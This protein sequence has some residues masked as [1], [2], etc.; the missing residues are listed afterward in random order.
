MLHTRAKTQTGLSLIE[1]MI[2][3]VVGLILIAGVLS[4]YI[5]SRQGY[6]TNSAVGEVQENGRFAMGF[7]GNAVRQA[8]YMGCSVSSQV[9]NDLNPVSGNLPYDFGLGVVGFEYAGTAPGD[10]LPLSGTPTV[11]ASTDWSPT[12]DASLPVPASGGPISQND[13][14]PG[15]DVLVVRY[16]DNDPAYVTSVTS[17]NSFN[18]QGGTT[19]TPGNIVLATNCLSG[20]VM[21][22]TGASAS[23]TGNSVTAAVGGAYPPGNSASANLPQSF[24][25]A[26]VVTP[27]TTALY[28]GQ[29]L[30]KRPALFEAVTDPNAASGFDYNE[31]VPGVEN[32]QVL[33]GLDTNGTRTP[34][35][36]VTADNVSNWNQVVSV[37]VALLV[38]SNPGAIPVPTAAPIYKLL[39][40]NVTAPDDTRLRRVFVSDIYI[41]N[42]QPAGS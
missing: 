8:G 16:V 2:A 10:T 29:G 18:V 21:Q 30:D 38:D 36:Y 35:M 31:L 3:M 13:A 6:G 14:L 34:S 22:L 26:Q 33:Y 37:R 25:G 23:G 27:V 11:A 24:V 12:L 42:E 4:I 19:L 40:T 20:I 17:A 9:V 32:M 28:I 41:R 1:M 7:I 39:D 5:T 15:S